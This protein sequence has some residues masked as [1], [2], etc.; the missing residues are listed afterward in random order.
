VG[1]W[2]RS[3]PGGVCAIIPYRPTFHLYRLLCHQPVAEALW[4][5]GRARDFVAAERT[6]QGRWEDV[7]LARVRRVAERG[8]RRA[9]IL[10]Q[11]VVCA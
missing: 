3:F 10:G 7:A 9:E 6:W 4:H 8:G 1:F 11:H 2:P 5:G